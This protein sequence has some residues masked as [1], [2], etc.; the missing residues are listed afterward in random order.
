MKTYSKWIIKILIFSQI[1][2]ETTMF[3]ETSDALLN[4]HPDAAPILNRLN[5]ILCRLEIDQVCVIDDANGQ[6]CL[7]ADDYYNA[8]VDE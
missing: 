6:F 5:T 8:D 4:R 3:N 7:A 1:P 2:S